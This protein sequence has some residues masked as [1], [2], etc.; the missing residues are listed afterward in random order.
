MALIDDAEYARLMAVRDD[1]DSAIRDATI[2]GQSSSSEGNTISFY[3]MKDLHMQRDRI[4]I[5]MNRRAGEI[6]GVDVEFGQ[7]IKLVLNETACVDA[8]TE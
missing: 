7:S 5:Q 2:Y 4:T 8:P 6:A 1:I 3:G